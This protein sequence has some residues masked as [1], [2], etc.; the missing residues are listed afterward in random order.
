[1]TDSKPGFPALQ[2]PWPVPEI[3]PAARDHE[4]RRIVT[5]LLAAPNCYSTARA[6]IDSLVSMGLAEA[7]KAPEAAPAKHGTDDGETK[8]AAVLEDKPNLT[9]PPP[10]RQPDGTFALPK[11]GDE[12]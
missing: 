4:Y 2:I 10:A 6:K 11:E 1:M 8:T 9:P 3:V 12:G 5:D 7:P